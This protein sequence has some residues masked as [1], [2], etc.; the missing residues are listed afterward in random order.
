MA[1]GVVLIRRETMFFNRD[2]KTP[3][4]V[5][6]QGESTTPGV[7]ND[8]WSFIR[9]LADV[10]AGYVEVSAFATAPLLNLYTPEDVAYFKEQ[11]QLGIDD[12]EREKIG[13]RVQ[14]EA[15]LAQMIE[16]MVPALQ[17]GSPKPS[18]KDGT[19]LDDAEMTPGLKEQIDGIV[20]GWGEVTR[21]LRDARPTPDESPLKIIRKAD[22]AYFMKALEDEGNR[23]EGE[24][25][26]LLSRRNAEVA[27]KDAERAHL[28]REKDRLLADMQTKADAQEAE[29]H[30]RGHS[31]FLLHRT[32]SKIDPRF[33][34]GEMVDEAAIRREV[35]RR[36]FGDAAVNGRS[37]AYV[38]E[39]FESLEARANVDPF[40]QVV[41]DGLAPVLSGNDAAEKAYQDMVRGLSDAHKTQ[42]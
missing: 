27:Q 17:D 9:R 41:A 15:K 10:V 13:T 8:V 22:V 32:V 29:V 25:K 37:E 28:L 40:A 39:R 4:S 7:Q 34:A 30:R 16:L 33:D 11:V 1:A 20:Q 6:L 21:G 38:D 12:I 31:L 36:K 19:P 2:K 23:I 3:A 5:R 42:H 26:D 14:A 35:V 18:S 24:I